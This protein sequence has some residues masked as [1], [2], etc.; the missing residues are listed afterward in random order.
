MRPS[1]S[2][3]RLGV[4][5]L[6]FALI[7]GFYWKL[8][9]TR[10]YEWM[11]GPDLAEQVLPWFDLQAREW[12]Q[13]R[14]PLW[15][16]YVWSGQPLIGQA[17]PGVAYP[18]NWLLFAMPLVGG[19]ISSVALAWYYVAI[20]LMAA[21][22]CYLLCR[23]LG[24]SRTASIAG[25]LIFSLSGYLGATDWPQMIN[26][27]VWAP[28]V[29]LFQL[30]VGRGERLAAN[31]A[32]SGL[33]LG[34]SWLSGHHQ[35]PMFV[36]VAWAG[37]WICLCVRDRRAMP[38]AALAFAIAG[39]VGALQTLPAY[40]YG[41]MARRWAGAPEPLEWNQPVPYSV[42]EQ[43]DLKPFSFFGIVFPGVKMH[44][45]PFLGVVALT[46]ALLGIAAAWSDWRVKLLATLGLGAILYALGHNSIFQGVLYAV[47]PGLDKARTPSAAVL[48]FQCAAAALAAF[49]ADHLATVWTRRAQ[50]SLT[51]FGVLTL[52]I[53]LWVIFNNRLTFPGDDRVILTGMI[54]LLLAALLYAR[55]A[56]TGVLLV[57][58]LL[59]ELGNYGQIQLAPRNDRNQMQWLDRLYANADIADYLR[60]QP[61]FPRAE[62]ANDAFAENWGAWH[63]VEMAG[64]NGAS[65]TLNVLDSEYFSRHGRRMWG[66]PYTIATA[67]SA[68]TGEE[69]FA[70][71]TGMK[72]YRRD[73]FPRAWAVHELVQVPS[74]GRGNLAIAADPE[75]FRHKA[76]LIDPPPRVEACAAPEP[77]EL[78]EHVADRLAIRADLACDAMVVLSDTFYPG[79]RAR[80]DHAPARIYEVNG[81]MRG[82]VVPRGSHTVTMR[83][84][85]VSVY[86]GAAL[87]LIGV[88]AALIISRRA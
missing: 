68:R 46:L 58:L 21:A 78:I 44:F 71:A 72:V 61:G 57:T 69:V 10:Q 9:L 82:V 27:A 8:T 12:H 53:A 7:A 50:W 63:G 23:D 15:D 43:Y 20:H 48:V 70:G 16:P 37:V 6:L 64:G 56:A 47:V 2:A 34:V 73:A 1:L 74:R 30:R 77:V 65:I 75:G 35:I 36:S 31:A 86:A 38:A 80:V 59:L 84:R 5:A 60:R 67:P 4:A 76:H 11:R 39:L 22:F 40:E 28:L 81:A 32:L 25:G 51:I 49:G 83:Y 41:H 88:L 26:G 19:H 13:G 55:P 42:H 33:F 54:A 45:D 18:L 3:S 85:P 17:Q 52:G 24:R 29:F 62:V 87:T 14:I 66:V 79:W